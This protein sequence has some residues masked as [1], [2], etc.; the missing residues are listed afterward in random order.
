MI[1]ERRPPGIFSIL[2]DVNST[3][4]AEDDAADRSL[5]SRLAACNSNPHFNLRGNAFCVKH[6][7]GDVTYEIFGM[8]EKNKDQV[9]LFFLNI[10]D[11]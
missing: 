3:A 7:A 2:N 5:I 4:H 8:A 10:I 1:E 9:T 11:L 6:Y